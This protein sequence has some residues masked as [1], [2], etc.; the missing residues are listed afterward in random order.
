LIKQAYLAHQAAGLTVVAINFGDESASTIRSYWAKAGLVPA[1]VLDPDETA[2][3]AFGVGLKSTGLPV[4]V[5]INRSGLIS[6]YEP[7]PLTADVL[8]PALAKIL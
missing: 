3:D 2:A 5:F 4:S 7:F 1:P 6:T 8:G